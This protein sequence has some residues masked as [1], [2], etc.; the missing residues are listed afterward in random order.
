MLNQPELQIGILH[1][2]QITFDFL[3]DYTLKNNPTGPLLGQYSIALKNGKICFNDRE[4]TEP[5][6]EFLPVNANATFMLHKVKIGIGFHWEQHEDQTFKGKLIFKIID[7]ELWAI[8]QVTTEDYITSVITSEMNVNA[9]EE[10]VKAHAVISR[11]WALA[12]LKAVEKTTHKKGWIDTPDERVIW[13][14]KQNHTHFDL[15]AD[16]HCQRYQG[17]HRMHNNKAEKAIEATFGEVLIFRNEI[18]DARFSKCC[19]GASE[20]FENVWQPKKSP[21]LTAIWDDPLSPDIPDLSDENNFK[22]WLIHPNPAFCNTTNREI[23]SSVLN[24]YDQTTHQF[25]RWKVSYNAREL[26][27]LI[28]KKSGI[29]FGEITDLKPLERGKSG[30]II[31]LQITGTNKSMTIG[32]ELE[33]RRFLSESH[34][35]S[36]AFTCKKETQNGHIQFT[37][38][39]AGWGHGVGLCQIGAAVMSYQGYTYREI[40][41]HYF[42]GAKTTQLYG[43]NNP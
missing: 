15:C 21:Y 2:S 17:L 24:D 36:S 32:K 5:E 22:H 11:S 27:Q 35:L 7:N 43:K 37:L 34:L 33:I 1:S 42:K 40:L 20:D 8:N 9:P 29:D 16:D 14:D 18:C 3:S 39:G 13:Y 26:G 23:L 28:F 12:Q 25:F 41:E 10:F 38:E 4:L 19:G 30:R 6:I 31:K